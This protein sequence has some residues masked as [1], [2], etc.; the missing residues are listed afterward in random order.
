MP[1]WFLGQDDALVVVAAKALLVYGTA[2]V[3]LRI[4]HRRTLA[5]WTAIDFAAAVAIGAVM[6][7]TAVAEGQSFL[8]GATALVTFLAAHA[9]V[10]LGR[11]NRWVAK[12]VDHRVRVLVDHGVLRRDQLRICGLTENDV[13]AKL[14]ELGVREI[15]ELRYVLYETKGELTIVRENGPEP[16]GTLVRRG[17]SDAAGV[18][19]RRARRARDG[20]DRG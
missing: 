4:A 19:H 3:G 16:D 14:R 17:L 20:G 9:V 18:D 13:L 11:G 1:T 12:A 15:A 10:T 7:R 5:Q 6:G 8:V 2:V